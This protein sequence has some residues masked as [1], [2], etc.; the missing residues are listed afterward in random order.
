MKVKV[1]LGN[2]ARDKLDEARVRI[3][4]V[5]KDEVL[6]A[7]VLTTGSQALYPHDITS[8]ED[9]A[10]VHTL[11]SLE[12]SVCATTRLQMDAIDKVDYREP[13]LTEWNLPTLFDVDNERDVTFTPPEIVEKG[14]NFDREMGIRV[15]SDVQKSSVE[16]DE[17]SEKVV[18]PW[19]MV[20]R[21]RKWRIQR[22][23]WNFHS[24]IK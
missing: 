7:G 16:G 20:C 12:H 14:S 23:S 21:K 13:D 24:L 4:L 9:S 18:L 6:L 8:Q 1:R 10:F 15:G 19:K 3:T 22:D 2:D 17:S 11:I 5:D